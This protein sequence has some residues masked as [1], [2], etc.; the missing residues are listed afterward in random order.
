MIDFLG[1]GFYY[2][3]GDTSGWK[4][5]TSLQRLLEVKIPLEQQPGSVS[6]YGDAVSSCVN[7]TLQLHYNKS[8]AQMQLICN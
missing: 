1:S 6:L 4:N 3:C 7:L 5:F 2:W 8:I